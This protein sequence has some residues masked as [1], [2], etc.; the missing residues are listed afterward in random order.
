MQLRSLL[1]VLLPGLGLICFLHAKPIAGGAVSNATAPRDTAPS[2]HLSLVHD[3]SEQFQP[4]TIVTVEGNDRNPSRRVFGSLSSPEGS[5]WCDGK[6]TF[7]LVG[8]SL[9]VFFFSSILP[10]YLFTNVL[11]H[12]ASLL[13]IFLLL[14]GHESFK[15]RPYCLVVSNADNFDDYDY[16]GSRWKPSKT[17]V[18][19]NGSD[20]HD[21]AMLDVNQDGVPDVLC[22]VGANKGQSNTNRN[23]VFL[24]EIAVDEDTGEKKTSLVQVTQLHGLEKYFTMRN[25]LMATLKDAQGNSMVLLGTLGT[26]RDDGLYVRVSF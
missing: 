10:L 15:E 18:L 8:S 11:S 9:P 4:K 20:R 25:R 23:E 26:V 13:L 16:A 22:G 14:T 7:W 24:T 2:K 3:L 5:L 12:T 21:C 1:S 17:V 6:P 19:S